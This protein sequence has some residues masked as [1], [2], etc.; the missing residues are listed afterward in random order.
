MNE[1]ISCIAVNVII[2]LVNLDITSIIIDCTKKLV[3]GIGLERTSLIDR[4]Q[5]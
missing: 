2:F 1:K 5:R 3:S 4:I